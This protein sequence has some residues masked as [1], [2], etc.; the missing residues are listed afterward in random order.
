MGLLKKM[1]K[2]RQERKAAYR[3]AKVRA[4]AE[5]KAS[6]KLEQRKEA[7][8]RKTAKQVRKYE[9]KELKQR[10]KH[11]EKMAKAA[12]EQIKQGSLNSK[13]IMRYA[14]AT[15]VAAPVALPLLY[16]ALNQARSASEGSMAY[17]AGVDR[18]DMVE[19]SQDGAAHKAR[20]KKVRKSLDDHGVPSG[21]AKD[22]KDRMDVLDDA[23]D[24]TSTMNEDQTKRVLKSIEKELG[25]V[26]RQIAA[27][28]T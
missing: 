23:I 12:V 21:F 28:R 13:T 16:R 6:T 11:E 10:R 18:E 4:K 19:Y 22:V 9:A 27:K 15:R 5:A 24:N 26:E 2:R 7:Y 20:I 14:T 1:R 25:L 8:L 17:R 3:A